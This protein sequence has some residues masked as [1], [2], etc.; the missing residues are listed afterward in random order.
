MINSREQTTESQYKELKAKFDMLY[1][2]TTKQQEAC[3][4]ELEQKL[5]FM[6]QGC[7]TER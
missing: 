4:A 5:A 6:E 1:L 2:Q 3:K 7:V